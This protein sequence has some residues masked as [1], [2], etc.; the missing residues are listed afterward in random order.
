MSLRTPMC[1]NN[2]I[3][4]TRM[5]D[6]PIRLVKL[7]RKEKWNRWA[8]SDADFRPI[9]HAGSSSIISCYQYL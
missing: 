6:D 9:L 5:A 3:T 7:H 2:I 4:C 1:C 8:V